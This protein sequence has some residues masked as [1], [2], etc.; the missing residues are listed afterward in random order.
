MY[1]ILRTH[2]GKPIV[3]LSNQQGL[4][5]TNISGTTTLPYGISSSP[6]ST[7]KIQELTSRSSVELHTGIMAGSLP[8]LKPMFKVILETT[9]NLT[10]GG[11]TRRSTHNNNGYYGTSGSNLA[12]NSLSGKSRHSELGGPYRGHHILDSSNDNSNISN[13]SN[14][15]K[16]DKYN[17]QISAA[18]VSED[19]DDNNGNGNSNVPGRAVFLDDMNSPGAIMRT[20]EVYVRRDRGRS[21]VRGRGTGD[22]ELQRDGSRRRLRPS[23]MENAF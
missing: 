19:S 3:Y 15:S 10:S 17:V 20:T 23:G 5:L 6:S 1:S 2:T 7:P 11:R 22:V 16:L 13:S 9:K 14:P 12:M 21:S 8:A 18:Q 4:H